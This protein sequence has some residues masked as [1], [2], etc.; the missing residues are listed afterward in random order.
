MY[1]RVRVSV[2]CVLRVTPDAVTQGSPGAVNHTHG[3]SQPTAKIPPT[4]VCSV[5]TSAFHGTNPA[6]GASEKTY[7]YH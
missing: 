4:P 3:T 1:D 2:C 6:T 5:Q 7:I